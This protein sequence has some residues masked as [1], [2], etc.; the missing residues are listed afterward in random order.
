MR[1]SIGGAQRMT[2]YAGPL[3]AWLL[4]LPVAAQE[5]PAEPERGG[6]EEITITAEK[7]ESNLQE[8]PVAVTAITSDAIEQQGLQDFNDVQFVAP[9]LVYGE[10]AD[11]AQITMRGIG[12]D[13]STIDAE[14]GVG[15]Y[16]DGVY[17]GG[18]TSSAGLFFDLERIEVLRGPQG[19][20][21]GRNTTGGALNV[22]TK[23]PGEAFAFE[24]DALYGSHDRRRLSGAVDLPLAPG[25][26]ALRAAFA[27]DERDGYTDNLLTGNEEDDGE[28]KQAKLA[29]VLTPAETLDV[30]LRFNWIDSDYGGPPF[31]KTFDYPAFPLFISAS[32]PGGVLPPLPGIA[33]PVPFS[34]PDPRN[35]R[36]D[37]D[38]EYTRDSWDVNLT[39]AWELSDAITLK[40]IAGYLDLE[41]DLNPGNNDGV[42][43][44]LLEG[45]YEQFNEEWQHEI[46]LSGSA[47][48]GRLDWI[49]GF[50]YYD[51][52]IAEEYR[53]RLPD[54]QLTYEWLFS[55]FIP[56]CAPTPTGPT[57]ANPSN[58]LA[59]FG[60]TLAGASTP[61]PFLEFSLDQDLKSWALFT[62]ETFHFTDRLRVT[63]G[64]RWSQDEKQIV[65]NQVLNL[66]P[67]FQAGCGGSSVN[68]TVRTSED[69]SEPTGKVGADFDLSDDAMLYA[70]YS[71]GFKSGGYNVGLCGNTYDPEFVNAYEIGLKSSWLDNTVRLN[72]AAFY[73][74]YTD[75]QARQFI[76]NASIIRNAADAET[77]GVELE[78]TW[79][80]IE[81]LRLDLAVS[82]LTA[83]Y[84][85]FIVDDPM[86][87]QLGTIQCPPPA[88][89]GDL[90]QNAKGN[91]LPRA[92]EWKVG[93]AAQYDFDLGGAGGLALRGEYAFTDTQYHDVFES[94]FARQKAY[95][96]GNLRAI[97][98][99]PDSLLPG[100][101][102]QA[103]VENIGDE[104]Y[105][106]VHAPNATT[107]STISNFG[108]PR[109]WGLQIGYAWAA[110]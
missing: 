54:L 15:L 89:P 101:S 109:T 98:R 78:G 50:F 35:V 56:A 76:N 93:A 20:L 75:Y 17:R 26:L 30:T 108:P 66:D 63:A 91:A 79:I 42:P 51:S 57:T 3:F 85:R 11:M 67:S 44:R 47:L 21:Y 52:D 95:S 90:C 36:Y 55:G 100:L 46:N 31:V 14:P 103:F 43:I 40:W 87:S 74:D 106:T 9:A 45:D 2:R 12:V 27:Y 16:Q 1:H 61:V 7:R 73:N 81:P 6:I 25:L 19:T 37:R 22:I 68:P 107:G 105:V 49:A 4:A 99:A 94:F 28:A 110:E 64:F 13:T 82:Y 92:P 86:N 18:L 71:R 34:K 32:D 102:F 41:Q 88:A 97:W 8:T 60:T 33:T 24:G 69:W 53:Y 96:V 62:Q 58:C 72:V 39:V 10:I 70:S 48:D 29:A 80:P 38:Q 65:H 83:Q 59:G 84:K 104:D 23:L 5:A 77:Y